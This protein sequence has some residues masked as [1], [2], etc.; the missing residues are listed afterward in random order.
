[1]RHS[2]AVMCWSSCCWFLLL[3]LGKM[4]S[5][6]GE[7]VKTSF[8]RCESFTV[9]FRHIQV[10][11]MP[12][13]FTLCRCYRRIHWS[14]KHCLSLFEP[15]LWNQ[16]P[17]Q[18]SLLVLIVLCR[19]LHVSVLSCEHTYSHTVIQTIK[20]GNRYIPVRVDGNV[21]GISE[22]IMGWSWIIDH[23]TN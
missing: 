18:H 13:T 21:L 15:F 11:S 23:R 1:M 5:R 2:C 22:L 17:M 20:M 6:K 9:H 8:W 19:H 3:S 16:G 12:T 14:T 7:N 10:I 4:Y